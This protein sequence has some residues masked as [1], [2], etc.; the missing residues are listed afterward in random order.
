MTQ[1]APV[2][3]IKWSFSALK[4]FENCPRRYY[5]EKELKDVQS[6]PGEAATYGSMLH[7]AVEKCI[8]E[9]APLPEMFSYVGPL[10]ETL[11]KV[12]GAQ[13]SEYDLSLRS[14]YTPTTSDDPEVWYKGFADFLAVDNAKRRALVADFKTGNPK[15]ADMSQLEIYAL[16][17]FRHFPDVDE[18][19]GML[20]FTKPGSEVA[21]THVF[22]RSEDEE[23]WLRWHAKV[24]QI[25]R[26]REFKAWPAKSS[27]LCKFCPVNS[28][29]EHPSWKF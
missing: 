4:T 9:G 19:T 24:D 11:K 22:K 3:P 26:A 17:T 28:C 27:G 7:E 15:Y 14:D 21:L 23:R 1:A 16:A 20:L 13:H 25:R 12:P 10:V 5:H 18:V 29:M 2:I 6:V 8:K